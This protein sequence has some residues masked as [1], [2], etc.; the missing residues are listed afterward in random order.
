RGPSVVSHAGRARTRAAV[1]RAHYYGLW[2]VSLFHERPG[3]GN[4]IL[5]R[6]AAIALPSERK[7]R[8]ESHGRET[9]R[10]ADHRKRLR[11]C[12]NVWLRV[13]LL[14]DDRGRRGI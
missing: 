7:G 8:D 1:L 9:V 5:S 6:D 14:H 12:A 2:A 13:E 3:R 4:G 10:G 11:R